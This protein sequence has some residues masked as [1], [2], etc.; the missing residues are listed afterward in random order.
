[1]HAFSKLGMT[2]LFS[3]I[4]LQIICKYPE[5]KGSKE[6]IVLYSCENGDK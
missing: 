6:S 3:E 5:G 1:M 4:S 2:M